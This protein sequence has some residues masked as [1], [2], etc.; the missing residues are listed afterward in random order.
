MDTDGCGG[1]FRRNVPLLCSAASTAPFRLFPPAVRRL[2][3]AAVGSAGPSSVQGRRRA[4][5]GLNGNEDEAG[6]D[7][8]GD[9]I[10][11]GGKQAVEVEG[12]DDGKGADGKRGGG[13]DAKGGGGADG[14]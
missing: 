6:G 11:S 10:G 8:G 14:K 5:N 3:S 12:S 2:R 4:T 13:G 9:P 1:A 7:A